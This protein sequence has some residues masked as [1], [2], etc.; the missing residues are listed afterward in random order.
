MADPIPL[1][2]SA[3]TSPFLLTQTTTAPFVLTGS[4]TA[5]VSLQLGASLVG[6]FDLTGPSSI[7]G[8]FSFVASQPQPD[9]ICVAVLAPYSYTINPA[10][11]GAVALEAATGSTIYKINKVVGGTVTQIG[12]II[13]V[14]GLTTGSIALTEPFIQKGELVT[15]QAPSVQDA[16]LGDLTFLLAE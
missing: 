7:K 14:S 6:G 12:S 13:F 8:F 11:S 9:E 3:N 5:T 16:T 10:N 2:I 4:N 15:I 1:N